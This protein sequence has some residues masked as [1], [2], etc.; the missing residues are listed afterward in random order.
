MNINLIRNLVSFPNIYSKSGGDYY[1]VIGTTED[2]QHSAVMS[3][4]AETWFCVEVERKTG[5]GTGIKKGWFNG[6]LKINR[7]GITE[8]NNLQYVMVG[9]A[10]TDM[11]SPELYFDCVVVA[12]AYI[13]PEATVKT[14]SDA[15]ALSDSVYRNKS[16]VVADTL[17][18]TDVVLQNKTVVTA[19]AV[20]LAGSIIVN[21]V[22]QVTETINLVEAVQVGVGSIK[23]TKLFLVIGELAVQ[24]TGEQANLKSEQ[25]L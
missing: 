17:G 24:L 9:S 11:S 15:L 3:I 6:E 12:D 22:L 5:S 14:V 10:W 13:G 20:N 16:L 8:T 19:D 2:S 1:L 23:K 7:T 25:S 4:A 18:L 21:K